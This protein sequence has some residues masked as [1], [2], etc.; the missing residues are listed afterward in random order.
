M[1]ISILID[2]NDFV[3]YYIA[4]R[5]AVADFL[6]NPVFIALL[7]HT[8]YHSQQCINAGIDVV[9]VSADLGHSCVGTTLNCYSHMFQEAQAI[10][11]NAIAE[12]LRFDDKSINKNC[13]PFPA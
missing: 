3:K 8:K 13:T 12:A 6:K 4:E 1:I 11:S 7:S 5:Q 10:T 2:E 9:S